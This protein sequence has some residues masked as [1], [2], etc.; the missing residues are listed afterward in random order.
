[1]KI[2]LAG[3]PNSG[4]TTLFNGLTGSTAHVGN[5]PG[6]TV[7][8]REG[9]YKSGGER[10][11]IVDLPGIY[12][13]SPYSPEEVVSRNVILNESP[14]VIVNIV[15]ATNLERNLY[16]TTQ[17]LETDLPVVIALNMIDAAEKAGITID[18]EVLSR[19]LC[20]PVIKISALKKTGIKELMNIASAAGGAKRTARSPIADSYLKEIYCVAETEY[21]NAGVAHPL[22]H[23]VKAVESDEVEVNE[24]PETA[25]KL[26]ELK[27][28]IDNEFDGDFEGMVADLRYKYIG[29]FMGSVLSGKRKNRE[30]LS[31]SDEADKILTHRIWGIPIFLVIMFAVF[32]LT[33]GEDLLFLGAMGA[34]PEVEE[35]GI[36]QD[37]FGNGAIAS[38][39]VILQNLMTLGT[40]SLTELIA[41]AM[42]EGTWYTGLVVDGLCAGLFSVLSFIPQILLLFLFLS[43][44]EDTGYM[45]RVAFIMDRAFRKFG[46]SGKA[47]MP[48]LMCFG[49]AVPGIMAT[50]TLENEKER[51][52]A[53]ILAPFFSCGAKL[54]IWGAFAAVLFG[55]AHADLI[56][57]MMYFI[58]IAVAVLSAIL[59]RKTALKGET[60]PFIMELPAYHLPQFKNTMLHLWE[61]LKHYVVRA[62][63]IIAGSIVVI[64]FLTNFGF[65]FW[66]GMVEQ[67][68]SILGR[69]AKVFAWL[70]VPLGFGM[71]ENGWMFVV[72][73]FSGLI[74]KEMVVATLGTFAGIDDA[75]DIETGELASTAF[76]TLV[77]SMAGGFPAAIAFMAFNLLSVPCMAA[78]AAASGEFRSKKKLW[79][80]VGY[81]MAT[82]YVVSA[83]LFVSLYFAW[84]GITLLCLI[85]ALII[86]LIVRA[87]LKHVKA[88]SRDN[89]AQGESL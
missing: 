29:S 10:I 55:G 1:M 62:A 60:A 74:A 3:N 66:Q 23:A 54:P 57:F 25:E 41:G 28:K 37:I 36:V 61:K 53:I 20:V 22:F 43:L 13:L 76:G 4:K 70:F 27:E 80:A 88:K 87:I 38:P 5:Y 31:R 45:A 14:D 46:L 39:G 30:K 65:A 51:R 78:V 63:T 72:A 71:G 9:V 12:S 44:L 6:V 69:I 89:G 33:F 77:A 82:A 83:I 84:V 7:E 50:R 58:G 48:L 2:A 21:K 16:L 32:H 68:D 40:D 47:F 19:N 8:K 81:W 35:A 85:G 11:T 64:W 79:F 73:A 56:V 15:D 24:H 26:A 49:C 75:L 52:M 86:F 59:L 34:I 42:P 17:L 18:A 67:G